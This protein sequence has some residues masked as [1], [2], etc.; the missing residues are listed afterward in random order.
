MI[1]KKITGLL[2]K[3]LY[4]FQISPQFFLCALFFNLFAFINFFVFKQFFLYS[5]GSVNLSDFFLPFPYFLIVV[6]PVLYTVISG[7]NDFDLPF[8]TFEII[9]SRFL[10]LIAALAVILFPALTFPF[11]LK[12]S[13]F[14]DYG[15]IFTIFCGIFFY[16]STAAAIVIFAFELIPSAAFLISVVFL[17]F[18]NLIHNLLIYSSFPQFISKS[19]HFFSFYRHFYAFQKGIFDTRDFCFFAIL[20]FLFLT[21]AWL[22]LEKRKGQRGTKK[23]FIWL[24]V[25]FSLFCADSSRFYKRIDCTAN[26]RFTVSDYSKK[27]LL[28]AEE[29]LRISFYQSKELKNI[30]PEI[31]SVEDFLNEYARISPFVS[32]EIKDASK[33][34]NVKFLTRLGVTPQQFNIVKD[35]KKQMQE[36]YSAIVIEYLD[37]FQFIPFILSDETLEYD[38]DSNIQKLLLGTR[39]FV[40][41]L[42]GNELNFSKDYSYVKPWLTSH[43]FEILELNTQQ[44]ENI[45]LSPEIPLLIF[46]CSEINEIQCAKIEEFILKGG[47]TFAAVSPFIIDVN[48]NWNAS[49]TNEKAFMNMLSGFGLKIEEKLIY[50]DSDCAEITMVS[51]DNK[52][53]IL[54]YPFW[55]HTQN[56]VENKSD[57]SGKISENTFFMDD[58]VTLFWASPL[59]ILSDSVKPVLKTNISSQTLGIP[60]ETNPFAYSQ[61]DKPGFNSEKKSYITGALLNGHA[62]GFYTGKETENAFVYILTDQYF[63]NSLLTGY[64]AS[65]NADYRNFHFL[66]KIVLDLRGEKE[67]AALLSKSYENHSGIK[68][69][70]EDFRKIR[71]KLIFIYLDLLTVV[72]CVLKIAVVIYRK[73]RPVWI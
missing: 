71:Q 18:F 37:E 34:E 23:I 32:V 15:Q 69:N 59:I 9:F 19:I 50:D 13:G 11:A 43:G 35:D 29:P 60:V 65:Q 25:F 51:E 4:S 66:S 41:M 20:T 72:I 26:H 42:C 48:G 6:I 30:N 45:K 54:K 28:N 16:I 7:N 36:V 61:S 46:G 39:R 44:L 58:S 64:S 52:S 14:T 40:Y 67:M 62:K 5:N 49:V 57:N 1:C 27:L 24:F 47:K 8:S 70:E 17:V 21:S 22:W 3:H 31:S 38:L 2:K 10:A 63:V 56:K 55:I 53:K 68:I 33:T 12:I 73:R